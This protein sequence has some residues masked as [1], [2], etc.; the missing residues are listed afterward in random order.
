[1]IEAEDLSRT[2]RVAGGATLRA[3]D[4]F[5]V[6]VPRGGITGLVGPNGAGKTTIFRI[7][8]GLLR[9]D[10]GRARIGGFD[11]VSQPMKARTC[12]GLL[13]EE[14]GLPDRLTPLWHVALHAT[15]R[16]SPRRES[17][18][19]AG[20]LLER[21]HTGA[22]SDRPHAVLSKGT[23]AKVA[24]ARA[25]VGEPMA[26]ILDEPTAGLDMETSG[27]M[28]RE[29]QRR[30]REGCAVLLAT[31]QPEEAEALCDQ[32]VIL[33]RGV[34][35]A[36]GSMAQL[37]RAAAGGEAPPEALEV[38][39]SGPTQPALAS[40]RSVITNPE[41]GAGGVTLSARGDLLIL[42]GVPAG[43]WA[44]LVARI[45][46]VTRLRVLGFTRREPALAEIHDRLQRADS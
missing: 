38:R 4:R 14:P 3:L 41:G 11:V 7:L 21:L 43:R 28:R 40:V 27:W 10:T 24:L 31:H 44:E 32:I 6:T 34:V 39:L 12:L 13:T 30:A 46:S 18:R 22:A 25:L 2:F 20:R 36:R 19:R 45:E 17:L 29:I 35:L 23:R 37:R 33:R 15:L 5:G 1:M 42:T 16:G 8:A 26:L 9:P